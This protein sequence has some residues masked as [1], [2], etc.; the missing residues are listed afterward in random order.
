MR[1]T[2]DQAPLLDCVH[3]NSQ[4][5]GLGCGSVVVC[6]AGSKDRAENAL[7]DKE[8]ARGMM[9]AATLCCES[10]SL[11]HSSTQEVT[12][13]CPMS[14]YSSEGSIKPRR[15]F[16]YAPLDVRTGQLATLDSYVDLR[17]AI[18]AL[19]K[20]SGIQVGDL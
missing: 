10:V 20:H 4:R 8:Q 6:Q 15:P 17:Q 14:F 5:G 19:R 18:E 13:R 1:Q 9:P 16:K 3:L 11:P 7:N 12:A 2:V